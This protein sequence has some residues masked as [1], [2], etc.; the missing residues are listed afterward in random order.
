[1]IDDWLIAEGLLG[2][3]G[4]MAAAGET[5]RAARLLAASAAIRERISVPARSVDQ[6]IIDRMIA[7]AR[8]ALGEDGFAAAWSAGQALSLKEAATEVQSVATLM[9]P[10]SRPRSAASSAATL[11]GLSPREIDVLRLVPTGMSDREIG[12]ALFV[13]RRTVSK[14]VASILAKLD[15]ATRAAA[16]VEAVRLGLA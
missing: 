2:V 9:L 8:A 6:R 7:A 12:D 16:S 15:V 13:S 11:R 4:L 1:M 3:A 10:A 5:E 14:H